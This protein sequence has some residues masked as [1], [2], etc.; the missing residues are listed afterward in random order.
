MKTATDPSVIHLFLLKHPMEIIVLD[1][2]LQDGLFM[3]RSEEV[4][5]SRYM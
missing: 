3:M 1:F 4:G 5:G 2:F